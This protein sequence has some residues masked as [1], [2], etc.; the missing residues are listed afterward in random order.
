MEEAL[1]VIAFGLVHDTN[2]SSQPSRDVFRQT[3]SSSQGQQLLKKK[4]KLL[5]CTSEYPAPIEDI[6]LKAMQNMRDTFGLKIGYSDH[7]EGI[8]VPCMAVALGAV[9][10]EKHFTLDRNLD[11]PDHCA[12]LEP[13]E[14]KSMVRG[15]RSTE[16][17]LGSVNKYPAD[18]ELENRDVVR[19]SL[20]AAKNIS[21]GERFSQDNLAIKRHGTGRSPMAY[22]SLIGVEATKD[23]S[24]DESI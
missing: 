22:W 7:S 3:Y 10:I 24:M 16:I 18:A 11:G 5:H 13:G 2:A 4:V 19:K 15:I 12:S 21:I 9:V 1:S 6:N 17:I 8:Q 23:Y 20:V 14:L